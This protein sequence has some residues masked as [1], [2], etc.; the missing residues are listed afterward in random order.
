[1]PLK[2]FSQHADVS[3]G[4][5]I[6]REDAEQEEEEEE[7][8][9][10]QVGVLS[11]VWSCVCFSSWN[12]WTENLQTFSSLLLIF[13]LRMLVITLFFLFFFLIV[14]TSSSRCIS[15][16]SQ[17]LF[18]IVCIPVIEH[19][20]FSAWNSDFQCWIHSL[21]ER[22]TRG[23]T[24]IWDSHWDVVQCWDLREVG[25]MPWWIYMWMHFSSLK[26]EEQE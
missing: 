5:N 11:W 16:M 3:L 18:S 13:L 24:G 23:G 9:A 20:E 17:S 1:M 14:K 4:C 7:M 2:V 26:Q 15:L 12:A 22:W 6:P 10:S 21:C 8:A 19:D 25:E